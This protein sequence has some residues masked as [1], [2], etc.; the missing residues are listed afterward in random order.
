[1]LRLKDHTI[2]LYRRRLSDAQR[3]G[4]DDGE[5]PDPNAPQS[6]PEANHSRCIYI[7]LLASTQ[8][9][10]FL[11]NIQETFLSRAYLT[12]AL[13]K[14]PYYPTNPPY[15]TTPTMAQKYAKDQPAGFTNRIERVAIVGVS[16]PPPPPLSP[17]PQ[18]NHPLTH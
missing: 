6:W 5:E 4:K 1:M 12:T 8:R 11:N 2:G 17:S 3:W 9:V 16:P 15:S 10:E 13:E 7:G 14:H 18:T